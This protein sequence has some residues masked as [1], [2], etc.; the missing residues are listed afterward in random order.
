MSTI[1]IT[2]Q[3]G[4]DIAEE[5]LRHRGWAVTRVQRTGVLHLLAEWQGERRLVAVVATSKAEG[6]LA[7]PRLDAQV[8]VNLLSHA[9]R[10]GADPWVL[11]VDVR[12]EVSEDQDRQVRWEPLRPVVG[13]LG[14]ER[15]AYVAEAPDR[16][17]HDGLVLGMR[18]VDLAQPVR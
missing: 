3:V 13:R 17:S 16:R 8:A 5:V 10:V 2:R 11:G 9:G 1:T 18:V 7:T 14:G 4:L 15:T 12:P 6:W